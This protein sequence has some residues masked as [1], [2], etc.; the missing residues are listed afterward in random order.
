MKI[1]FSAGILL[2]MLLLWRGIIL[3]EPLKM[4]K[5]GTQLWLGPKLNQTFTKIF[6]QNFLSDWC[7]IR[8][9]QIDIIF[10]HLRVCSYHY[11]HWCRFFSQAFLVYFKPMQNTSWSLDIL[12]PLLCSGNRRKQYSIQ[13]SSLYYIN[14]HCSVST[15]VLQGFQMHNGRGLQKQPLNQVTDV[16][17]GCKKWFI[18]MGMF[19]APLLSDNKAITFIRS[20]IFFFKIDKT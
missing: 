9:P 13:F 8:P 7:H 5:Y 16:H 15:V 6:P 4:C 11:T 3:M 20:N 10:L 19:L 1:I 2:T 18:T 12:T 17:E 14:I